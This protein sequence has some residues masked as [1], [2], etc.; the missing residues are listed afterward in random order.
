[1][2]VTVLGCCG[3]YP[4]PGGACSGYLVQGGGVNLWLDAGAGTLAN[5]QRHIG[6]D[7]ID[8]LLLTHAHPDH[9]VDFLPWH[10]VVRYLRK[11]S[12]VPVWSTRR[13]RDLAEAVNGDLTHAVDWT[14]IDETSHVELGGLRCSFSR[15][16]HGPETLAVRVDERA[17]GTLAYSADTGNGWKLSSLG[18]G[19][20]AALV[21]ATFTTEE[22]GSFQHLS[23]RQAGRQASDAGVGHL[24]LTHL[25]PGVDPE[26]QTADAR[27]TFAGP[28]DVV[29]TN[30]TYEIG[31]P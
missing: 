2:K 29:Q 23:A 17:G 24:L 21:E 10:N 31:T 12:G 13:T 16:D 5:L 8:G 6:I 11:R 18:P 15:T 26:R 25:P 4:G 14:V 3:S 28:V 20:D 27:S 22:E 9:W 1:M 7:E 30:A 19:I